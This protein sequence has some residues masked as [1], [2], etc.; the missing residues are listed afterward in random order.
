MTALVFVDTNVF[1]YSLDSSSPGKQVRAAEWLG[2]LWRE[3]RG[4]TSIQVLSEYYAVV[5]R[6]T[7]DMGVNPDDAWRDVQALMAWQ[8]QS[9]DGDLLSRAHNIESR[10]VLNWWDSLIVAA[11]QVQGCSLLLTEDLQDR[12]DYGGVS[13][14][15]PFLLGVAEEHTAY[16]VLPK[17]A[18]RH[19]GRG[20]PRKNPQR[21]AASS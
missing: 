18:S 3:Q 11:A 1:V 4:R 21:T 9:I 2:L 20:R 6:K 10:Y 19:R 8:P 16:T 13:I 7:V 14:R 12:A 5:K 17:L 15:N